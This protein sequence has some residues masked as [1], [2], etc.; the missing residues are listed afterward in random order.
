MGFISKPPFTLPPLPYDEQALAPAISARTLAF[1][2]GKHHKAYIDKTNELVKGKHFAGM[3]LDEIV[4]QTADDAAEKQLFHNAA[5]AWNHAFYWDSL[6]PDT[7]CPSS[8]L[9]KAIDRD[10]A[11]MD[12]LKDQLEKI[13]TDHFASGWAWLILKNGALEVVDSHDGDTPMTRGATCLFAIDVWEHAYYLD[14]QNERKAYVKAVVG[15]LLN[16]DF[17]SKNFES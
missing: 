5:Q 2:H 8:A 1:H 7:T 11:G 16:W 15:D 12:A 13:A 17:A 4:R 14:Y 6:S 10:C 3:A 9:Q